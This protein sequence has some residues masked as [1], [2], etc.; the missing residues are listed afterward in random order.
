MT[1]VTD[2]SKRSILAFISQVHKH[3]TTQNESDQTIKDVVDLHGGTVEM[4]S[5]FLTR[6]AHK[7]DEPRRITSSILSFML[8]IF[9]TTRL[10]SSYFS[11]RRIL[12]LYRDWLQ[13]APLGMAQWLEQ[14][15]CPRRSAIARCILTC[16]LRSTASTVG[17]DAVADLAVFLYVAGAGA[18]GSFGV[19]AGARIYKYEWI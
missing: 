16:E 5:N 7:R 2:R 6:L 3:F 13:S 11:L 15:P 4:C 12:L 17:V 1:Q 8:V 14:D 19:I 10:L 18:V 9:T